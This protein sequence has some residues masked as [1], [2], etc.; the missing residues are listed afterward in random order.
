VGLFVDILEDLKT[1]LFI[2]SLTRD[3]MN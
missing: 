1:V 2:E 3:E